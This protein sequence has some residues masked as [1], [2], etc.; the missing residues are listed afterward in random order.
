MGLLGEA[1]VFSHFLE[2]V[3]GGKKVKRSVKAVCLPI[4][5]E[6]A[7]VGSVRCR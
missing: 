7:G 1:R 6:S 3:F 5:D 4:S 2:N